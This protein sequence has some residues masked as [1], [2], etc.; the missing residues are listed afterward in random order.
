VATIGASWTRPGYSILLLALVLAAC[1][2]PVSTP[3]PAEILLLTEH[4]WA[5]GEI[6]VQ[7]KEFQQISTMALLDDSGHV[8]PDRWSNLLVLYGGDTLHTRRV[9]GTTIAATLPRVA[10]SSHPV[11]VK[12]LRVIEGG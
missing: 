6:L 11:T 8:V 5:G 12:R 9:D 3:P 4:Q 1:G 2:E 10:N 7:S